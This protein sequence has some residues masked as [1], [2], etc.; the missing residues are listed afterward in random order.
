[1][2][3]LVKHIRSH[4]SFLQSFGKNLLIPIFALFL[5][6]P[7]AACVP[8]GEQDV[9]TELFRDKDDMQTRIDS[10]KVGMAKKDVFKRLDIP[11]NKFKRLNVQDMQICLYGNSIVQGT[12]EELE[13]FRQKMSALEAYTLPYREIKSSSSLGFAKVRVEKT[14]YDLKLLLVFDQGKLVRSGIEG[15]E[16]VKETEEEYI[17]Q[18]LFRR[19]LGFVL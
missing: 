19:G 7:L 14:G 4:R 12:P 11:V 3:G 1:M 5:T 8:S 16:E 6:M 2:Q 18:T 9:N 13:K 17:W 10:L 15:T